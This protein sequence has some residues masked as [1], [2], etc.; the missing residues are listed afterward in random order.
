[1]S[2]NRVSR[3]FAEHAA[4]FACPICS[5]P[6]RLQHRSLLC[7]H[8]HCFDI[9]KQGYVNL[10]LH[11]PKT[12]YDKPLFAARRIISRAGY[13]EPLL[14]HIC[15]GIVNTSSQGSGE[16]PL[17]LLDAGCGEGSHLTF[18]QQ[19]LR[20]QA[21]RDVLGIGIDLSREGVRMAAKEAAPAIW[22]AA[23]LARCPIAEERIDYILNIL[24]PSNYAEFR[25]MLKDEGMVI[26]AIPESDHLRQ[27]RSLFFKRS[28][29]RDYSNEHSVEL[30]SKH[31][32]LAA[33]ERVRYNVLVEPANME[34]LIRM[35]PLSWRA[36]DRLLREAIDL[37]G[38]P[39]EITFD[40]SVLFGK[41]R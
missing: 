22:C 34:H 17:R 36:S 31:F 5:Q 26:K 6:M 13:F 20:D 12:K 2:I 14:A 19:K 15:T 16:E 18:I 33:A 37:N 41:K 9:A 21:W 38:R 28:K 10:M 25:R 27:L 40:F 24:S 8:G 39:T 23:D 11:T 35:T 7:T 32:E 1:M 4:L 30:F 29:R 3:F